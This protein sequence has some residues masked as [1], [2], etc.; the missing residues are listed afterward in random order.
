MSS[1]REYLILILKCPVHVC[2]YIVSIFPWLTLTL[3]LP[4]S[5]YFV[6]IFIIRRAVLAFLNILNR[7]RGI[8]LL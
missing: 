8:C 1:G 5:L 7:L 3:L 4:L 2:S 6:I